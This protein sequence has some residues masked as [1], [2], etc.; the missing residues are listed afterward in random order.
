MT[1]SELIA[2]GCLASSFAA[3]YIL[4][5]MFRHWS[6]HSSYDLAIFDQMVW[7]L[8]RFDMPSSSIKGLANAFGDH[9]H[10]EAVRE[11]DDRADD[12]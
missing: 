11:L 6:F 12:A 4:Y 5:G 1:R 3:V 10:P 7:Q 9:F 2:V 8:A